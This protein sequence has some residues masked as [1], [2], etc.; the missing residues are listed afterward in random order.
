[1]S[2]SAGRAWQ[3]RHAIQ[4]AAQLPERPKDALAVLALARELVENFLDQRVGSERAR[5]SRRSKSAP[6]PPPRR[7]R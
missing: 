6:M 4:I 7:S 5:R 1:M 2:I 3:R